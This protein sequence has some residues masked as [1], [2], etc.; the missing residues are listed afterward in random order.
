MQPT[1]YPHIND[2]LEELQSEIQ[3][4]LGTR[5]IGRYLYGS[6]VT[7]GFDEDI[8]DIDLLAVTASDVS[9]AELAGLREM[10]NGFARRHA[11]WDGRIEVA[12]LS[13]AALQTFR[14]RPSRIAIISPGEPLHF[15]E[16]GRDWLMNWYLVREEGIAL[17]GPSP[18]EFIPPITKEEFIEAVR[19]HARDSAE[20]MDQARGRPA[21][22]YAILTFCRTLC[23]HRTGEL[24]SK[25]QAASWL[26]REL[27]EW[28]DLIRDAIAWRARAGELE[29]DR[30]LPLPDA[31][32]FMKVMRALISDG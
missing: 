21:Q 32:R 29:G 8:S 9:E 3:G 30:R 25:G 7:G 23:A 12:Y 5:V 24:V 15:R 10:H 4:V 26:M 14:I 27:P 1:P 28:A 11:T 16:A 17:F 22:S 20:W 31:I 19:A 2:L 6:L 18:E 13:A